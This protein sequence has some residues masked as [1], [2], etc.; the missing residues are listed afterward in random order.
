M[1][2]LHIRISAALLAAFMILGLSVCSVFADTDYTGELDPETNKPIGQ[3]GAPA[4]SRAIL[5]GTMYY[6]NNTRD[7]V[8]PVEGSLTEVHSNMADGMI[9]NSAASVITS[10]P[11]VTVYC[12]GQQCTGDLT[13]L[14]EVGDYM[15][16]VKSGSATMRLFGFSIVGPTTNS[17]NQYSVPEGFYIISVTRD[18]NDV[19]SDYYQVDMEEE[20]RYRIEYECGA[21]DRRYVLETTIDRTPPQLRFSGKIDSN[22]RVH[23][24]LQ[25][26]GLQAGDSIYLLRDATQVQPTVNSDGTGEI[27]DSGNYVMRVYDAAG[28]MREYTFQIMV[29]L[30]AGAW[31][32][33]ILVVGVIAA[34]GI[35]IFLKKKKLKIG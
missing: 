8:Y 26:S 21:T 15:V 9:T 28:N 35:Y 27:T 10:D 34:V 33:V 32:F 31:I 3:S 29:Y 11:S 4:S 1:K 7:Y 23:S 20:G 16:S 18:G 5:S 24:K 25:F 13:N 30:N 2:K 14:R 22:K 19:F 17:V 12:N 6:D